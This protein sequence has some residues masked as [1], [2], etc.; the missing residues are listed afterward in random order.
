MI[1]RLRNGRAL[2]SVD[3]AAPR[4]KAPVKL[5]VA[6][7]TTVLE[8]AVAASSLSLRGPLAA[9]AAHFIAIYNAR[10]DLVAEQRGWS[11]AIA[12]V[13]SDSGES[14]ALRAADGLLLED[15]S[16]GL[17][18]DIVITSDLA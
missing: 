17:A 11:R 6:M 8:P 1:G 10:P 18:F 15:N 9:A 16:P 7:N 2:R 12:L 5:G 13:A 14:V 3:R 4:A